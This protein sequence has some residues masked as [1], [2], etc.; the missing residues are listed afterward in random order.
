MN[1]DLGPLAGKR[2]LVV[3]DEPLIAMDYAS[4]L[5]EAGAQVI[6]TFAS[7]RDAMRFLRSSASASTLDAAVVDFVLADS[8][9]EPLQVALKQRNVPFVVVSAHP[10]ALVRTEVSER[11]LQK[12][13][14][15]KTLCDELGDACRAA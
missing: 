13:V 10:R 7:V 2:V 14:S 5:T 1:T 3:E 12:P 11:I 9:S 4:H 15:A 8:N 6:G